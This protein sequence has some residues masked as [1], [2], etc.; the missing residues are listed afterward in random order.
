M[1]TGETAL[2]PTTTNSLSTNGTEKNR[3]NIVVAQLV[4]TI[5]ASIINEYKLQWAREDRPRIPNA[6]VAS[7]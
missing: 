2:D 4:S 7:V 5:S 6:E 1:S 3:N